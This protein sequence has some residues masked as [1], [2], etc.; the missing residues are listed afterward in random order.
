M[1]HIVCEIAVIGKEE[2]PLGIQ[3]EPP[4]RENAVRQPFD[5][6]GDAF[7]PPVVRH[8]GQVPA[9]LVEHVVDQL[10]P[11][12]GVEQFAVD[13]DPVA[14]RVGLLP[15]GGGA[16]VHPDPALGDELLGL[17]AGAEAAFRNN[18]LQANFHC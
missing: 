4:D 6:R 9:G 2:Q 8:G 14:V 7:P 10:V 5:Q 11:G 17:A 16:S 12:A 18:F 15:D 13:G 1:G 3:V